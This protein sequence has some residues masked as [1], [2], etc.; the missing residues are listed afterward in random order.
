MDAARMKSH[1]LLKLLQLLEEASGIRRG[2]KLTDIV[3]LDVEP[4]E[5]AGRSVDAETDASDNVFE[6]RL[7]RQLG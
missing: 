3:G 1:S 4:R 6:I 5:V 2:I 7:V